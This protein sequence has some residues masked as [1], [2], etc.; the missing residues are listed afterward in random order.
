MQE[1]LY[2]NH[3]ESIPSLIDQVFPVLDRE[4]ARL[5]SETAERPIESVY[6]YGSGD[7]WAAALGATGAFMEL[8]RLPAY[9]LTSMQASRYAPGYCMPK[10]ESVLAIG[11]SNSGR[12][13]RALEA[14]TALSNHGYSPVLVTSNPDSPG[15]KAAGKVFHAPVPPFDPIPVPGV[16]S[17]AVAQLS[18]YLFAVHLAHEKHLL[19]SSRMDELIDTLADSGRRLARALDTN[20]DALQAFGRLCALEQRVEFLAAGPCRGSADFGMAKTLEASGYTALSPELEEFSHMNFFSLRPE[21]IPTVL[22]CSE[23]ARCLS[24]CL[25]LE[26]SMI[27]Q[28]RP[29]IVITD[30]E[31]FRAPDT[32]IIRVPDR[33]SE[34]FAPLTFSFLTACLT[35]YMP[36]EEGDIYMHDHKGPF[37]EEGF[38]TIMNSKLV[39]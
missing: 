25:E 19:S 2:L 22:I 7:S 31:R 15:A 33:L 5:A 26:E 39:L 30:S 35:A 12:V 10:P 6:L 32:Q 11:V 13:I 38:P 1:N 27:H 18:L 24:R 21:H 9:A 8:C 4:A 14:T 3:I 16:R 29:Y 20:R 17:Y 36:L 23:D 34:K 37:L 28:G